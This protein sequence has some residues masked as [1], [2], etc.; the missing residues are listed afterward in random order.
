MLS[1]LFHFQRNQ[2]LKL[3]DQARKL[4][5]QIWS[6]VVNIL[7]IEGKRLAYKDGDPLSKPYLR[8]R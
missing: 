3:N 7:I 5:V 1:V 6:S 2:N 8:L 4:K